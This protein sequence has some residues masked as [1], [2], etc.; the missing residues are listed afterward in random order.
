MIKVK[1]SIISTRKSTTMK[2]LILE[3]KVKAI[4]PNIA[5]MKCGKM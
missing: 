2:Y 4:A 5:L 3:P 1:I